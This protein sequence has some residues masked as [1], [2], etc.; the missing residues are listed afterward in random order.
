MHTVSLDNL[1]QLSS[2]ARTAAPSLTALGRNVAHLLYSR[3]CQK[4][5]D[6]GLCLLGRRVARLLDTPCVDFR[7]NV[8]RTFE[9][10]CT[11]ILP[12][13]NNNKEDFP[14]LLV[15]AMTGPWA[16]ARSLL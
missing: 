9:C 3:L 1:R 5:S 2:P 15:S 8:R 11:D 7:R 14:S 12:T 16:G 4:H 10:N 13:F 6:V